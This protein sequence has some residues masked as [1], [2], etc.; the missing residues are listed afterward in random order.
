MTSGILKG[1]ALF[2]VLCLKKKQRNCVHLVT[3]GHDQPVSWPP[4]ILV[5][6]GT[7]KPL[8]SWMMHAVRLV[9]HEEARQLPS[10][11]QPSV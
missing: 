3:A 1:S 8:A 9:C 7:A 11:T 5:L 10:N 6:R 2:C 4:G